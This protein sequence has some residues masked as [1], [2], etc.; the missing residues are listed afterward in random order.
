M[1]YSCE[2]PAI[3]IIFLC[4]IFIGWL[5]TRLGLLPNTAKR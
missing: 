4:G 1:I 5:F 3:G 2:I